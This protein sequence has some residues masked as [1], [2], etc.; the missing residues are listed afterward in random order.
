MSGN[1]RILENFNF[2]I[3]R[4]LRLFFNF[5]A[6]LT[7]SFF[8]TLAVSLNLGSAIKIKLPID[9]NKFLSIG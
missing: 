9:G 8:V 6:F 1:R 5:L 7:N 2:K 4:I 3:Y